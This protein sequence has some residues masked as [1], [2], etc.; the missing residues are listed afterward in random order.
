MNWAAEKLNIKQ[1]GGWYTID[2]AKLQQIGGSSLLEKVHNNS[3]INL[4]ST[5]YPEY[6]W[7]PWKFSKVSNF[8][9]D[10]DNQKKFMKWASLQLGIK[11]PSDWYA[12]TKQVRKFPEISLLSRIL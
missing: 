2:E 3:T 4:L 8:W 1:P 6:E 7:L 9:G 10:I 5:V 12:I 11:Q